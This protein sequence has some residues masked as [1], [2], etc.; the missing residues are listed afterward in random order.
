MKSTDWIKNP[1]SVML[2]VHSPKAR[3][4]QTDGM[5]GELALIALSVNYCDLRLRQD[6]NSAL[7][8]WCDL[9]YQIEAYLHLKVTNRGLLRL[10]T[11]IA[12]HCVDVVA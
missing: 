4:Y 10:P 3:S 7:T 11:F 12:S 6:V 5:L 8:A 1:L 9:E 2:R